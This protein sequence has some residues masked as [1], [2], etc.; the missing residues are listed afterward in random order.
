MMDGIVFREK[1][2]STGFFFF[3]FSTS[4]HFSAE[5]LEGD[6]GKTTCVFFKKVF[7]LRWWKIQSTRTY[8][9]DIDKSQVTSNDAYN[10]TTRARFLHCTMKLT[11]CIVHLETKV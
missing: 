11:T 3:V 2:T 1:N 8:S 7:F 4:R 6:H 9:T 5:S 10:L